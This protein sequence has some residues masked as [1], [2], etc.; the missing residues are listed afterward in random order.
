MLPS[1]ILN[2]SDYSFILTLPLANTKGALSGQKTLRAGTCFGFLIPLTGP[3]R[4]R[5][6]IKTSSHTLESS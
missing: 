1:E 4:N 3:D 2:N 5:A 6:G